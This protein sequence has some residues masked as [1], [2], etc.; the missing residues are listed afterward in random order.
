MTTEAPAARYVP[1][2][3]R[4]FWVNGIFAPRTS[5][6]FMRADFVLGTILILP[7]TQMAFFAFVAHLAD[8]PQV[9]VSFVVIGNAVA[10]TT[11]ATVFSICGTTDSEKS[12]GTIEHLLV[13][14]ANRLALYVGRGL[15]PMAV[16]LATVGV[17]M[18]YAVYVFGV[19]IPASSVVTSV[20]SLVITV[21]SM[22]GFGLLLAGVAFWLRSSNVLANIFLFIGFV[23]AGANFPLSYLPLPLQWVGEL[24][25]LT[26]GIDA[27][28]ESI[29]GDPLGTIAV[30]WG[31]T[32]LIG[33]V[34]YVA[35]MALW[36]VFER[37][38]QRT[39]SI[40]RW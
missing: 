24:L 28:R 10:T 12:G 14:P 22:V 38:A 4:T 19:T 21:V 1:S 2:F 35:A 3:W 29:A 30:A 40:I 36:E 25:P 17:S 37:Q 15:V 18:F 34:A 32:A 7:L 16:A 9:P 13:T 8:N 5:L 39:G 23:L 26:W 6:S 31:I 11:Y 27:L 33:V 20:L